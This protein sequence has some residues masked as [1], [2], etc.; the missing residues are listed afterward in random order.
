MQRICIGED[1]NC[2]SV[3]PSV[4]PDISHFRNY[5]TVLNDMAGCLPT[6]QSVGSTPIWSVSVR[7]NHWFQ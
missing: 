1:L 3:C 6:L 2:S 4:Q 5:L 7:Y